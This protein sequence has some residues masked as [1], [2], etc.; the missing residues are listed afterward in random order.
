MDK[1]IIKRPN[2][3]RLSINNNSPLAKLLIERGASRL[4]CSLKWFNNKFNTEHKLKFSEVIGIESN[5]YAK[6]IESNFE[7]GMNY[8]NK[9][10]WEIDH[11]IP[12]SIAETIEELILLHHYRNTKPMFMVD[13]HSKH[14]TINYEVEI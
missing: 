4:Y 2:Y 10:L 5:K 13:N 11:I 14:D 1:V 7:D 8:E 3:K 9:H 12:I 6:Y